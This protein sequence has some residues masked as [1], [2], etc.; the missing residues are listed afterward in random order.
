MKLRFC[1]KFFAG[2]LR[3]CRGFR[4]SDVDR[5]VQWERDFGK[6]PA[7]EPF[8]VLPAPATLGPEMG[9]IAAVAHEIEI[10]AI[11]DFEFADAEAG[12]LHLMLDEFV[13][14]T[15]RAFLLPERGKAWGDLNHRRRGQRVCG[16]VD[17]HRT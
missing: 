8:I 1:W 9:R 6:H 4:I 13:I 5:G 12:D 3:V 15:E 7:V 17:R 2:S 14:P 11:R 16:I 10:L